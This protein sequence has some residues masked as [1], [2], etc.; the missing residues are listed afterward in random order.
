MSAL[1]VTLEMWLTQ[2]VTLE[3]YRY[4]PGTDDEDTVLDLQGIWSQRRLI[5]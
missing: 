4:R 1:E 5:R 3:Y 2:H